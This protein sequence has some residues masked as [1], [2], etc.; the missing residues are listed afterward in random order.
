ME[1]QVCAWSSI[2]SCDPS[3]GD[4]TQILIHTDQKFYLVHGGADISMFR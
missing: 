2:I 4:T 1:D 3:P